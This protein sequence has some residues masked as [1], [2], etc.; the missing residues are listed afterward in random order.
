[1]LFRGAGDPVMFTGTATRIIRRLQQMERGHEP[2]IQDIRVGTLASGVVA[3]AKEKG[4]TKGRIAVVGLN[5]RGPAEP[6]GVISYN[7]WKH[8]VDSLPKVEFVDVSTQYAGRM[9]VK[10]EEELSIVRYAADVGERA[11]ERMIEVTRPGVAEYEIYAA[12]MEVIHSHGAFAVAPHLIMSIGRNDLGWGHPMW[13]Y[14]GGAPR[15]VRE[16][17]MV[18]A[19]IFPCY[20]GI[21]TQQQLALAVGA[22]DPV[23]HELARVARAS[24]DAGLAALRPGKTFGEVCTAMTK[25]VLDAGCWHLTPLIHS[26]APLAFTSATGVGIEQMPGLSRFKG[27]GTRGAF[28]GDLVIEPGMTF[29][30]EPNACRA[31]RRVNIGGTVVVTKTGVEE[32][33]RIA[34]EMRIID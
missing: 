16:G 33:N 32:L 2:W 3:S 15:V 27:I 19:E 1:M 8:V 18:Q 34:A 28:G 30:L 5:S 7:S 6:D 12:I 13:T 29:E 14:Q 26:L 23:L 31:D 9:L 4:L 17:D 25:P 24:Y 22:V 20:G 21:E 10:S 11:C